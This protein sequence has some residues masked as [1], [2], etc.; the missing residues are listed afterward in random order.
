MKSALLIA[1]IA[2]SL[3]AEAWVKLTSPHFELY[4]DAG[5]KKGREAIQ[6]FEQA[7]DFF[8]KASPVSQPGNFPVRLILC[9]GELTYRPFRPNGSAIAYYGMRTNRDY[10]VMG[11]SKAEVFRLAL[12]EYTHLVIRHSGLKLPTWLNEGWAD[13]YSSLRMT[14]KGAAVGDML[15]DRVKLLGANDWLSFEQLTGV[16]P[17]SPIYNEQSRA[18]IF[19]AES[20]ALTHMLYLAPDY[21]AGFGAFIR[22]LQAGRGSETAIREAWGESSI[23]VFGDLRKY[24][25]RKKLFGTEFQVKLDKQTADPTLSELN[26]MAVGLMRVDLFG[27]IGKGAEAAAEFQRLIAA[28][29]ESPE[30]LKYAGDIA[31]GK[32]DFVAAALAYDRALSARPDFVEARLP[33]GFVWLSMNQPGK[34]LQILREIKRVDA[35]IASALFNGLALCHLA[36]GEL[37]QARGS[38]EKAVKYARTDQERSQATATL[39]QLSPKP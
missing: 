35:S 27:A 1:L 24:L 10:I 32:Q 19:Y 33:L 16:T 22:A 20:W 2:A 36:L 17:K 31:V 13:V 14:P 39:Q 6:Y 8:E 12:H 9:D 23:K 7:R 15:E 30:A 5:A 4:T 34:A 28:Y 38:A 26:P 3:H 18:G 21:K 37:D 11:D 25:M 29:P